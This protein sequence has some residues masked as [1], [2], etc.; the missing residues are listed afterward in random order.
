MKTKPAVGQESNMTD[1]R[2]F[3]AQIAA[4]AAA[5]ALDPK[6]TTAAEPAPMP[7]IQLGKHRVSRLIAGS[8]P[9]LGYSYSGRHADQQMKNYFT[10]ERTTEF[11]LNCERAGITTHQFA[12]P[13]KAL[14]YLQ[15]LRE[16]GSKM[17]F[18]CLHS[19]REKIK[20]AVE[21]TQ[22]IAM[23]HHGGATDRLF[24]EGKAGQVH[25]YVKAV[26]DAGV[27]AGVSAHN[28]DCIK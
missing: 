27:L 28:P 15:P 17:T 13:D 21:R 25:D 20:D 23:V 8:N 16:R 4:I 3:L 7:M 11:L 26:H 10:P 14:P 6:S 2:G 18:I 22:P 12:D 9:I 19:Q 5:A 24:A 1:R